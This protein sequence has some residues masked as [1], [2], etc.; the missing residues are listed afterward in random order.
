MHISILLTRTG[1][2]ERG[3]EITGQNPTF[4]PYSKNPPAS[5]LK[6]RADFYPEKLDKTTNYRK[7]LT[8][9][10]VEKLLA[11]IKGSRHEARDRCW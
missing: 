8:G 11:T 4:C 10:E 7:H 6:A 2:I 3:K 9:S 1:N 5:C